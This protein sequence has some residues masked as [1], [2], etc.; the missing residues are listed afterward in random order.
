MYAGCTINP[1]QRSVSARPIS[2]TFEGDT[3]DGVRAND[4]R[5]NRL[6]TMARTQNGK[7]IAAFIT[8]G[9]VSLNILLQD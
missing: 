2:N 4:T 8:N 1:T 7:L 5:I 6:P 9:V 3:N